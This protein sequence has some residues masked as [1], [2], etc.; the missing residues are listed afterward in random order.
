M[1]APLIPGWAFQN[2]IDGEQN[3]TEKIKVFKVFKN[4]HKNASYVSILFLKPTLLVFLKNIFCQN[5]I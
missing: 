2:N 5:V 3:C 1:D 4:K